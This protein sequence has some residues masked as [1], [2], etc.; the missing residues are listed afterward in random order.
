MAGRVGGARQGQIAD[1]VVVVAEL[2]GLGLRRLPGRIEGWRVWEERVAP[3]QQ[4]IGII[5]FGDMMVGIDTGFDLLEGESRALGAARFGAFGGRQGGGA[6]RC[7]DRRDGERALEQAA[8][9][10]ALADQ[11]TQGRVVGG[12]LRGGILMLEQACA[13]GRFI[14]GDRRSSP[15]LHGLPRPGRT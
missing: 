4:D 6:D 8:P 9:R 2:S 10:E 5:A 3:A 15:S 14:M 12:V 11:L 13:E 1:E 7:G